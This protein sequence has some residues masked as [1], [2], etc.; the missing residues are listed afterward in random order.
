VDYAVVNIRGIR[1]AQ[2]QRYARQEARPVELDY[3]ALT[4]M[5]LEVVA[6]NLLQESEKVRHNPDAVASV[7]V[8]LAR[9]GRLRRELAAHEAGTSLWKRR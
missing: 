7:A 6:G 5:G 8:Q 3:N 2:K 9:E 4:E 1:R